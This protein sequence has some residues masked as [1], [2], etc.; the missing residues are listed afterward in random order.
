MVSRFGQRRARAPV[1]HRVDERVVRG[2]DADLGRLPYLSRV[3]VHRL[4]VNGAGVAMARDQLVALA[5]G[6]GDIG[7]TAGIHDQVSG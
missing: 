1:G 5:L 3:L 2:I 6:G 4:V 7:V